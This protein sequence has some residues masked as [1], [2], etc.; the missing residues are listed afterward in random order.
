MHR[1]R[2]TGHD[3][4]DCRDDELPVWC[5]SGVDAC[6]QGPHSHQAIVGTQHR[7]PQPLGAVYVVRVRTRLC[8]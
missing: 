6:Q 1:Q 4:S 2:H 3:C 5:L 8:L 7:R